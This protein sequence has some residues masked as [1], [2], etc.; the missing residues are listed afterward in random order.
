MYAVALKSINNW[1]LTLRLKAIHTDVSNKLW[2]KFWIIK[3]WLKKDSYNTLLYFGVAEEYTAWRPRKVA[4]LV[5][6]MLLAI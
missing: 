4:M 2:W 5:F 6:F 1:D 3:M